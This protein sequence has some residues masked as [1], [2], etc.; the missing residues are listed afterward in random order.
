MA[1]DRG[2][3]A[4]AGQLCEGLEFTYRATFYLSF[5]ME[6]K[7]ERPLLARKA[8]AHKQQKGVGGSL[9]LPKASAAGA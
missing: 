3:Q 4:P 1:K 5:V 7:G 6:P 2:E 8:D 9:A